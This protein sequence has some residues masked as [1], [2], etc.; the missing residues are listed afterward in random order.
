MNATSSTAINTAELTAK[1]CLVLAIWGE[2]YTDSALNTL[3]KSVKKYSPGLKSVV[4]LTDRI[5][6]NLDEFVE[7][8]IF[9]EFFNRPD[10][11]GHGYRVKIAIFSRE[12]LPPSTPCVYLDLDTLV[13][14]DIGKIAR[15]IKNKEDI[16]M[17]PPGGIIPFGFLR[18][19]IFR[20]SSGKFFATGN[21]SVVAFHSDSSP[22]ISDV[23]K[24]KYNLGAT[25]RYMYID[26]VF[27]SWAGQLN[28]Q[29]IPS[30]LATPFRREFL[31]RFL[32]VL[33]W[34]KTLLYR[35]NFRENIVAITFNGAQYKPS[36]LLQLKAGEQINDNKG[37]FGFWSDEYMGP[38]R[39]KIINYCIQSI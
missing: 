37:R 38:I 22:S 8:K 21:S 15:L 29:G 39:K 6:P 16:F 30:K 1:F 12:L 11:F 10:F 24:E 13:L 3:V 7:Q 17:L 5:R 23:F 2:A 31:S 36:K 25:D 35:K 27:I 19:F 33:W 4:L 20:I 32:A 9:P 26:D 18:R 34:R 28:M 14:G